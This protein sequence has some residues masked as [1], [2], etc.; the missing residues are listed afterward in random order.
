[1]G[2]I[3][4]TWH[5][6]AIVSSTSTKIS[7]TKVKGFDNVWKKLLLVLCVKLLKKNTVNKL[8]IAKKNEHEKIM[9][10]QKKIKVQFIMSDLGAIVALLQVEN[11]DDLIVWAGGQIDGVVREVDGLD[12]VTVLEVQLLFA[13][14]GVPNLER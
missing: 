7:Q 12:D 4:K 3:A 11:S 5:I 6:S 8:K 1:M 10:S 14:N 2:V 9:I 13:R